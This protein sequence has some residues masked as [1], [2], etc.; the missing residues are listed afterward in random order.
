M[1][2]FLY[3]LGKPGVYAWNLPQSPDPEI[4]DR[5]YYGKLL[6]RA[7]HTVLQSLGV[8]EETLRRWVFSNAGYGAPPGEL[9]E[10]QGMPMFAGVDRGK[11]FRVGRY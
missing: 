11:V 10:N 3:T 6:L 4:V 1:I 9:P 7:A 2:C 5:E 8:K